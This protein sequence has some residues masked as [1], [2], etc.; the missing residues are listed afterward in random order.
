M[1]KQYILQPKFKN[2]LELRGMEE[3]SLLFHDQHLLKKI[4][5]EKVL[6][7]CQTKDVTLC[8]KTPTALDEQLRA[9]IE[10]HIAHKLQ[11]ECKIKLLEEKVRPLNKESCSSLEQLAETIK[12]RFPGVYAC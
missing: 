12:K 4:E 5:I 1:A 6:I 2:L 9:E 10:R 3:I 11:A 7:N 8:P